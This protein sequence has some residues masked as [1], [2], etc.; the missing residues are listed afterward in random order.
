MAQSSRHA[1]WRLKARPSLPKAR[2]LEGLG[3]LIEK[4]FEKFAELRDQGTDPKQ[5]IRAS[6]D[7]L[8]ETH[9]TAL[10]DVATK[11]HVLQE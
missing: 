11:G 8:S 2:R 9:R 5:A 3:G 10:A 7:M 4:M 1:A 6:M